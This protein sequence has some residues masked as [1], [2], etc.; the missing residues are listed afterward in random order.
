VQELTIPMSQKTSQQA[1]RP[2]WLNRHLW[3]DL[4]NK[5]KVYGLW[6]R[7]QAAYEDYKHTVE[8]CREK[9]RKARA[10]LEMN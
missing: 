1:R 8:L 6:K 7:G 3:L 9:I 5:R 10:Q 2:D 4:K